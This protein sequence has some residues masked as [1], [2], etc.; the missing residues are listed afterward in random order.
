MLGPWAPSLVR[1]LRFQN[2]Y[3]A[4]KNKQTNKQKPRKP[5]IDGLITLINFPSQRLFH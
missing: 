5:N 2:I 4:F 3:G 1:L